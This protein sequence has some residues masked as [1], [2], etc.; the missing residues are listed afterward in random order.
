[1]NLQNE[2]VKENHD[3]LNTNTKDKSGR[4]NKKAI[5][6]KATACKVHF[7]FKNIK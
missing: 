4:K 5:A 7:L 2:K 6:I 3:I 1:M